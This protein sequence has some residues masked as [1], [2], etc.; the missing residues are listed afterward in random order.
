MA[1]LAEFTIPAESFPLGSIFQDHPGV[2]VV[3][4]RVI[5]TSQAI[6][7]YFWVRGITDTEEAT[8]EAAFR[9]YPD[10]ASIRLID[11]VEGD[12]LMRVEWRAEY[13]GILEAIVETDVVL[14]SGTGTHEAWHIEVRGEERAAIADFQGYAREH[15]IPLELVTLHTLSEQA[16][17]AEHGLTDSQREA[18]IL[19]YDRGYYQS[20]REVTLEELAANL[21]ITGQSFG[22]RLRRGIHNLIG[23]T[24]VAPS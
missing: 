1:T 15:D 12:Y 5:P 11:E 7:P 13:Q 17:E 16:A 14:I 3:L 2:T 19:A 23:S 8:I 10:V 9:D 6:I 4:E 18:L 21:G 24:L 22:A 20:P